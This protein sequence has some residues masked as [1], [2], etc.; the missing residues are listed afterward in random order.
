MKQVHDILVIPLE[1]SLPLEFRTTVPVPVA[2]IQWGNAEDGYLYEGFCAWCAQV[3]CMEENPEPG[4]QK[5]II[6]LLLT[7][8]A[9][10][11]KDCPRFGSATFMVEKAT[12]PLQTEKL[13]TVN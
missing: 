13:P 10:H 5:G 11:Y 12:A 8:M 3:L 9:H 1:T 2:F 7:A 6:K 4:S